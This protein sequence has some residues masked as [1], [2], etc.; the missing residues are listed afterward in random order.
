MKKL[1][2][3]SIN[4]E[5]VIKNDEL[6]N[7]RGGYETHPCEYYGGAISK[8]GRICYGTGRF[9]VTDFNSAIKK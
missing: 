3:L 7:L 6:T 1:N 9:S 2:K 8:K 4:P 5:K